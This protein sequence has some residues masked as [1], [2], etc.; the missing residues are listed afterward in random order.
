VLWVSSSGLYD[1]MRRAVD[2]LTGRFPNGV[3][4]TLAG[5]AIVWEELS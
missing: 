2:D 4:K 3:G 5:L 1:F